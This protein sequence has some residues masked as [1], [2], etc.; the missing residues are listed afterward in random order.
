MT[1]IWVGRV[2]KWGR[3]GL[4]HLNQEKPVRRP[5]AQIVLISHGCQWHPCILRPSPVESRVSIVSLS[6]RII[7]L[8]NSCVAHHVVRNVGFIVTRIGLNHPKRPLVKVVPLA[9]LLVGVCLLELS[10]GGGSNST[11]T[12][13]PP[14]PRR[15]APRNGLL[16]AASN[17]ATTGGIAKSTDH[18][19]TWT[20]LNTGLI[21]TGGCA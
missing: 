1:V 20:P 19:A 9:A 14:P 3:A 11:S 7:A 16:Y 21:L 5:S 10:C 2:S 17:N 12:T 18:G 4:S 8:P 6:G 15:E 13:P